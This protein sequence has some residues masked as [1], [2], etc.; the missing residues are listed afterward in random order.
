M[1]IGLKHI[2]KRKYQDNFW[3][4]AISPMRW[5]LKNHACTSPLKAAKITKKNQKGKFNSFIYKCMDL[6]AY[7]AVFSVAFSRVIYLFF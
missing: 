3:H 2:F 6:L 7:A 4:T 5:T 1:D